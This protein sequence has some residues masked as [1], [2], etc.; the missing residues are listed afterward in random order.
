MKELRPRAGK[1]PLVRLAVICC[2]L[3][4][5]VAL[6]LLTRSTA[7]RPD[8]DVML[9]AA[10]KMQQTERA[11]TGMIT[12]QGI[13]LE[14]ED[15]NRTGLIGPQWSPLTSSLGVLEAKRTSLNPNFAALL[16]AY[17]RDAGLKPSDAIAVGLSGSFPGL[18]LAALSAA[19]VMGLEARVIASYGSSMYGGSRPEMTTIR[20]LKFLSEQ[21]LLSF[22]MLAVSPGGEGDQGHNPYWEDARSVVLTLAEEDGYRLL[23]EP[24]LAANI[25]KRI[26]LYGKD[27]KA[28]VNVGGAL[29]NLGAE[30]MSLTVRP[31]LTRTLDT[32]PDSPVR[33]A[34]LE[35][36]AHGVP[37]I[38]LLNVRALALDNGMPYDPVPLPKPGEG[39]VY[40]RET[41][42]PWPAL[43]ALTMSAILLATGLPR[44]HAKKQDA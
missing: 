5:G 3:V 28:F 11:L 17:Y 27:V 30:G 4:V 23:D 10:Q 41:M 6:T 25:E 32:M 33:G 7:L 21:G 37:V 38:H 9:A 16:A 1:I 29:A 44:R 43:V 36:L 39:G 18:G 26:A 19:D 2:G 8:Y 40:L 22:D 15:I 12:D 24:D 35:H 31:G 20:M 34:M 42:S 13:A 14:P